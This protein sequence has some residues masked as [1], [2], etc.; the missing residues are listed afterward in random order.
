MSRGLPI[1]SEVIFS[2]LGGGGVL[3]SGTILAKAAITKYENVTWFPSYAISRRGGFCEC[4]VVFS[5]EEIASPLLSQASGV[6]VAD[7]GQFKDYEG[8]VRPGG[9]MVVESAGLQTKSR[10]K[11][12][13][14][15]EVPAIE[16]AIGISGS[17]RGANLVLL[18]AFIEA[19]HIMPLELIKQ[20]I[21][22][23]FAGKENVRRNNLQAFE[24]GRNIIEKNYAV[25]VKRG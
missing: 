8:R 11:D 25:D 13:K 3:T 19:T 15:F 10:R 5:N 16:T 20:Q 24:E 22:K 18:G 23:S 6:S 21:E 2:G 17:S 12:I 1:R 7:S 4:T 14:I 9:T